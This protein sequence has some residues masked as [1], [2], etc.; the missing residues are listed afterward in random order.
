MDAPS[1][2]SEQTVNKNQSSWFNE[3]V[4]PHEAILRSYL[5]YQF[6]SV[7]VD[8]VVQEAYLKLF[9]IRAKRKIA[10]A[11]AYLFAVAKHTALR[12][13]RRQQLYSDVPVNKLPVWLLLHNELNGAEIADSRQR[14]DLVAEAIDRLPARCRVIIRLAV[15]DG[16]SAFEI[17]KSLCLSESTVRVQLARGIKKCSEY[18]RERG[19]AK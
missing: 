3:E 12:F 10:K 16:H 11:K 15:V 14:L 6:P 4:Q 8:D 18:L 1:D 17:A 19:E 9:E 5:H 7:D 2:T 13:C